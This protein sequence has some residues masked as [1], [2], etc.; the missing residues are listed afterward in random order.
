VPGG[1]RVKIFDFGIAKPRNR[2][3]ELTPYATAMGT[4]PYMPPEQYMDA[5]QV[6]DRADL[7]SLGVM[8]FQMLSGQRP[9]QCQSFREYRN[10]HLRQTPPPV[11]RYAQVSPGL[12]DVVARLLAKNPGKRFRSARVLVEALEA[13]PEIQGASGS[14]SEFITPRA[15]HD[16]ATHSEMARVLDLV[17]TVSA[18]PW[19]GA[20][21]EYDDAASASPLYTEPQAMAPEAIEPMYE[22]TCLAPGDAASAITVV[23]GGRSWRMTS[24]E[25]PSANSATTERMQRQPPSSAP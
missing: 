15:M 4:P 12:S 20:P 22:P 3:L 2:S 24:S 1:E 10:A 16:Q 11:E 25:T 7:Y 18:R 6:D 17:E 5:A 21:R 13:L 8:L 19:P 9:F 14:K 23:I